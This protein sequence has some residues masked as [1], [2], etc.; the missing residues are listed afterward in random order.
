[1]IQYSFNDTSVVI[2]RKFSTCKDISPLK[3]HN[4]SKYLGDLDLWINHDGSVSEYKYDHTYRIHLLLWVTL[5][6]NKIIHLTSRYEE[7]VWRAGSLRVTRSSVISQ[8]SL[9]AMTC[10][11]QPKPRCETSLHLPGLIN[12]KIKI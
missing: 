9:V 1:M 2:V 11:H 5:S 8:C 12:I 4:T 7:S 3:T 6:K 10:G